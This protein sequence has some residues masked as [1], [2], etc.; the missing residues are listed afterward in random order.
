MGEVKS[1]CRI[2]MEKHVASSRRWENNVKIGLR[3]I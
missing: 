2:L 1:E 3:V